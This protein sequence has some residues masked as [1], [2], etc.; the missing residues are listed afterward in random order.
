MKINTLIKNI[1]FDFGG[2]LYEIDVNK[3]INAFK[4]LGIS[5][6]PW[7]TGQDK[8]YN[9]MEVGKVDA[10]EI[11]GY[12]HAQLPKQKSEKEIRDAFNAILIGVFEKSMSNL[13]SLRNKYNLF[14][15]SNTNVIHH[16]KF[17]TEII[18]NQKTSEFFKCFNEVYYSFEIGIRKPEIEI[19]EYVLNKAN[20]I[21]DETLFVDDTKENLVN[22]EKLGIHT[23]WMKD[24]KDWDVMIE[25]YKLKA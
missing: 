9:L 4:Q 2:V 1:I 18:E 6:K 24:M 7:Q 17:H 8:I 21:P 10:K 11:L 12:F 16:Q 13:L 22:A 5:T 3:T 23:F 20:L 25:Q 15:L 19:F 14:M